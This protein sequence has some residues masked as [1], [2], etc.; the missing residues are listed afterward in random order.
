M[1]QEEK[2]ERPRRREFL[3]Q[4]GAMAAAA[5][6]AGDAAR[7]RGEEAAGLPTIAL[8]KHRIT[9][10]VTGWNPISGYSYQGSHADQHMREYFT[11]EQTV[12]YL[13]RCQQ[14]GINAAQFSV[15]DKKSA[16]VLAQ[17]RQR[18]IKL[19]FIGL[20]AGRAGI[21]GL[22]QSTDPIGLSHHGGV[23]D[24]LF[25][26]GKSQQ[27]HDYVKE[28]H[29]RGLLA[30]V[31][32]HNPDCIQRIADE[33]WEVDFFMTC[34]YFLTRKS[35]PQAAGQVDALPVLELGPYPFF[36][37]DPQVMTRVIRQVKQPCL[38]L[39]D[40]GRRAASATTRSR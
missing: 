3:K 37:D 9:R 30:G 29:D 14:A 25:A 19:S 16:D 39:Q 6:A 17:A 36:R 8:G 38:G 11:V 5:L 32:A 22:I 21:Q 26:E 7:A 23:T 40:P 10:L 20:H 33:G 1:F 18:G 12:E 27:V 24:K 34:F 15:S 2:I 35:V 28:V 31:S 4:A 13:L